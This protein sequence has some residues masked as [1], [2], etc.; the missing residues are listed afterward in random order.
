MAT[1]DPETCTCAALRQATRHVSRRYDDALAPVGLGINQFSILARLDRLGPCA[2]RELAMSLVMDRSTL[3]HL[4]RPLQ[5][6]GLL[7]LRSSEQD[8]RSRVLALTDEGRALLA[9]ARPLWAAAEV[10]F[11]QA[12]GTDALQQMRTTLERVETLD[13]T[14]NHSLEGSLPR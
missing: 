2:I 5:A 12:F 3:G 10:Q 1:S 6:R 8:R 9:R 13:L 4:L 14:P 7:T 11:E